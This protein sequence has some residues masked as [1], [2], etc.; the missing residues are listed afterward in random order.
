M[1]KDHA[2]IENGAFQRYVPKNSLGE[3]V[4]PD[5]VK[6]L[7]VVRGDRP[8][9]DELT[10]RL[11]MQDGQDGQESN[12]TWLIGWNKVAI[13][14]QELSDALNA[15]YRPAT[16][17]QVLVW[18]ARKGIAKTALE[19]VMVQALEAQNVPEL[20]ENGI[21]EARARL[22]EVQSFPVDHQLVVMLADKQ[23]NMTAEELRAAWLS[24]ILTI[25]A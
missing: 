14:P 7:P 4:L 12:G 23:L 10:E 6:I 25:K 2:F 22:H 16:R 24:E 9:Y 3:P 1:S 20:G 8:S 13:P 19:D 15:K 11:E 17:G 18:L 21:L 5:G